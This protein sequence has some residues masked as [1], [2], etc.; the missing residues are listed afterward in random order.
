MMCNSFI[1]EF[2]LIFFATLIIYIL[3]YAFALLID[4][5]SSWFSEGRR[6]AYLHFFDEG[7]DDDK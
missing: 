4:E 3:L 2:F 6:E 5:I 7:D 1:E